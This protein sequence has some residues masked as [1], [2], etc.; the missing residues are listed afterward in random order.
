[1]ASGKARQGEDKS[2]EFTDI[3]SFISLLGIPSKIPLST[4]F[5][6]ILKKRIYYRTSYVEIVEHM[7]RSF[8]LYVNAFNYLSPE[9]KV[10][11]HSRWGPID[12]S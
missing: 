3:S 10:R 4:F 12:F 9:G 2:T 1:M 8:A 7:R 5:P 11:K 6:K